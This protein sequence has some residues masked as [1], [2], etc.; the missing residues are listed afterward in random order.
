[1]QCSYCD[2]QCVV[3]LQLQRN[4]CS[5]LRSCSANHCNTLLQ[6]VAA[7][8][9]N[10]CSVLLQLHTTVIAACCCSCSATIAAL[11]CSIA[12]SRHSSYIVQPLQHVAAIVVASCH[13][14]NCVAACSCS[15]K[16]AS[17][18]NC[19]SALL[20]LQHHSCMQRIAPATCSATV[21]ALCCSCTSSYSATFSV[22]CC[23][24]SALLE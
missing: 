7:V 5:T 4:G 21:A 10:S 11:Y 18:V 19:S 24:C 8:A 1:M 20:Q 15:A 2:F 22:R 23:C 17:V 3:L 14:L 13:T 9:D 16:V 12:E 6:R